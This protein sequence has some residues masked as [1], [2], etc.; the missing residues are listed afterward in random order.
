MNANRDRAGQVTVGY[1]LKVFP[2]FSETF[3]LTELLE[4]ERQQVNVRVFSLRPSTEPRRHADVMRLQAPV[5]Y[6]PQATWRELP[7]LLPA[8]VRVALR[9]PHA[10]ARALWRAL[11][12][13][14]LGSWKHFVQAGWVADR[15]AREGIR[16][17]HAHFASVA[18]S[19]THHVR[20][21][22]GP[23]YSFTAHAKDIYLD[24]TN[25]HDLRRKLS[26][27]R[28]AV[29]VSEFN[30][31]HLRPLDERSALVRIYNGLD[32]AQFAYVE[33][34]AVPERDG[35]SESPLILAVG[36]LI[37]KKG[38]EYLVHACALLCNRGVDLRCKIVGSGERET[39]LRQL[40]D[41]LGVGERVEL[42][43]PL[44]REQLIALLP[45]ASVLAAPCVVGSDGNR[46]GLP[47]VLIEAMARGVPV[48]ATDVTGIPELVRHAETGLIVKQRDALALASAIERLLGDREL[49]A[50]LARAGR[51]IVEERFDVRRNVGSLRLLFEEAAA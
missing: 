33:R 18:T 43:G 26:A 23:T 46:D 50:R 31:R 39:Q 10:Y 2:R 47:T 45:Q 49:A 48:V 25:E 15:A 1:V 12:R 34:P 19:V 28:F 44:P 40:V 29:T 6:V 27:A 4:L 24:D 8:H 16:H 37:E 22:G 17:L 21:L 9:H 38:F 7:A 32:L 20:R 13:R 14:H 30:L 42:L 41:Q 35:A 3:I 11:R 36:R 51:R 5:R